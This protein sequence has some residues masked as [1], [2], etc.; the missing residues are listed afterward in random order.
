MPAAALTAMR[1][2]LRPAVLC[3]PEGSRTLPSAPEAGGGP[4]AVRKRC[5]ADSAEAAPARQPEA[6]FALEPGAV[7]TILLRMSI[8]LPP[9]P[10]ALI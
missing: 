5:Q 6:V 10:N 9:S 1:A 7:Q 3:Q 4:A 8:I 2:R